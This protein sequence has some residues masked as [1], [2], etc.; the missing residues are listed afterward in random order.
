[1]NIFYPLITAFVDF[2]P[3]S[4]GLQQIKKKQE[5]IDMSVFKVKFI[6]VSD[7]DMPTSK[8]VEN[9]EKLLNLGPQP[10]QE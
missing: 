9:L 8:F 5:I 10:V 1:M 4:E 7:A 2:Y 3:Q 6:L